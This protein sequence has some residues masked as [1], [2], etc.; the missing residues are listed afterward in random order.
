M[1]FRS[2]HLVIS[3]HGL[4]AF[5]FAPVFLLEGFK[6]AVPLI[7]LEAQYQK[8]LP[9]VYSKAACLLATVGIATF[10]LYEILFCI[11]I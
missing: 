10:A 11:L 1:N 4:V 3:A 2:S 7:S 6:I 5:V 8:F 9:S